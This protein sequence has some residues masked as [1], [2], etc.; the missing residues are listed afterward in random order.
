MAN[1]DFGRL[2][3]GCADNSFDS[4]IRITADLESQA[5]PH[6]P[7]K[8]AVYEGGR[9]QTDRRW[10]SGGEPADVVVVDAVPSQANRLE[11]ALERSP[12]RFPELVLDLTGI[13][14]LPAHLPKK[15]S[16]L[17]FPHRN[18]DAYLRD[19][20]LDEIDFEKTDLGKQIFNGTAWDAGSIMAWFPQALLYGFW[21]S[22]LGKK[23]QQSKH[24]RCWVSEIVGWHPATTDTKVMGLK[25]DSLNLTSDVQVTRNEKDGFDWQVGKVKLEGGKSDK[26]S[27]IGHGQV[28]FMRDSDA[29]PAGISFSKVTQTATVSFSQLRRVSL[30]GSPDDDAIARAL[31]VSMGLYAHVHAFGRAFSLRSGADLR[32]TATKMLW[33]G[34]TPSEDEEMPLPNQDEVSD[35][36]GSALDEARSAGLPV[37]GWGGEPVVLQPK[38]NLRK[39]IVS[40]W[41]LQ[42]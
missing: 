27:E 25:G 10:D 3:L 17:Q 32:P 33:M 16:S 36:L 21:Q 41:D 6:S 40:S 11:L 15:L 26:L 28:P 1:I 2:V 19:S 20:T 35:L 42:E 22:H 13:K 24:A 30:G 34:A 8:P 4:S 38:S 39:A 14:G 37:D 12:I 5:G 23:G 31:L 18:A 9:Y 29:T 7:V